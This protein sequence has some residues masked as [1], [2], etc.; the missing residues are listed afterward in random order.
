M[1]LVVNSP[2]KLLF[3]GKIVF[4]RQ[5]CSCIFYNSVYDSSRRAIGRPFRKGYTSVDVFSLNIFYLPI[6]QTKWMLFVFTAALTN[7][8]LYRDYKTYCGM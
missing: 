7:F 1:N 5:N 2:K 3:L 8:E 6:K 4:K